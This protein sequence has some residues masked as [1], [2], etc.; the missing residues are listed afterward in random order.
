MCPFTSENFVYTN[1]AFLY[2]AP[3]AAAQNVL[4]MDITSVSINVCF[5]PPTNSNQNGIITSFNVRYFG[6][7]FQTVSVTVTVPVVPTD[8]PLDRTVCRNLTGLQQ[9]NDYNITVMAIN[10]VGPGPISQSIVVTTNESG[11]NIIQQCYCT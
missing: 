9:N 7:P 3:T 6:S 4:G 10:S 5:D 8:Y 11:E 1:F 2:L